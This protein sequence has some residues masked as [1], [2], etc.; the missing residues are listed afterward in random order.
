MPYATAFDGVRLH[1][2]ESGEGTAVIL[3]HEFAG[4]LWSYEF[5]IRALARTFRCV[6]FN[7]RGYPPSDVPPDQAAY[8]QE[9]A[10]KDILAVMDHLRIERAHLV[11]VSMGGFTSLFFTLAHRDRVR[12]LVAAGCGFGADLK[13]RDEVRGDIDEAS[14]RMQETGMTVFA[15]TY[16]HAPARIQFKI[17]DPRG[18][19]E[20][21]SRLANHSLA[22][23]AMTLRGVQ[24]ERPSVYTLGTELRGLDTPILLIVGDEDE[25]CLEPSLFLKRTLPNAGLS[26][27][28]STGHTVNLEEPDA[29]NRLCREFFDAVDRGVRHG[30]HE[31]ARRKNSFGTR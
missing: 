31:L 30:R 3:V 20:F 22:G 10:C 5:Q 18:W 14:R 8:S 4:D 19:E 11:G 23:A 26:V 15:D 1:Y 24:R 25:A 27:L 2:E 17:K 16:A 9:S 28:P 12:S 29:F 13:T 21:R 6:A 7:A